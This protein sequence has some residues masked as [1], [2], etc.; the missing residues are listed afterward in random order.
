MCAGLRKGDAFPA[1]QAEYF[2]EM[3]IDLALTLKPALTVVDG[4]M[5]MEGVGRGTE[6]SV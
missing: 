1:Q 6:T 3:L 5:A 4:V 2:Q